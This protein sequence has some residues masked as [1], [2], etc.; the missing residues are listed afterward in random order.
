MNVFPYSYSFFTHARTPS[1]L[2]NM[3][4]RSKVYTRDVRQSPCCNPKKESDTLDGEF[5][6]QTKQNHHRILTSGLMP[7]KQLACR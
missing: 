7:I 6:I 4:F 3:L 1:Q 2:S 5:K